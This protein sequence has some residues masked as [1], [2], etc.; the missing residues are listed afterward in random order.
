LK[1]LSYRGRSVRELQE[2]LKMR[3]FPEH[4]VSSAINHLQHAGLINDRALAEDLKRKAITAK[5]LSQSSARR[6][7][8]TKGI[9]AEIVDSTLIPDENGDKENAK[10]LVDKKLKAIKN[11]P[12]EKIKKRLYSLLLR[13]GY[14][15]ETIK[16]VLKDKNL[17]ED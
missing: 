9:P 7:M 1:L 5:L 15:F 8:L 3:G 11:S 16:T 4:V 13:K 2:R 12:P 14:S 17:K 10:K 6:F